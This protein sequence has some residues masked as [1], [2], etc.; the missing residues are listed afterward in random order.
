MEMPFVHDNLW[1]KKEKKTK[2]HVCSVSADILQESDK[3]V[4]LAHTLK[5]AVKV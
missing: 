5:S 4:Y 1:N 2:F 3:A